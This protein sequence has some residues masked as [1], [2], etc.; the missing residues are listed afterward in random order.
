MVTPKCLHFQI[1][2]KVQREKE[3]TQGGEISFPETDDT[4]NVG[5]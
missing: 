4:L 5:N 1:I 3:F 2:A